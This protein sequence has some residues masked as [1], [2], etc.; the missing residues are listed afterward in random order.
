MIT[1]IGR[2]WIQSLTFF[3]NIR[4]GAR[5]RAMVWT[6]VYNKMS[7]LK[8]AGDKSIGEVYAVK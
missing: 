2:S 8:N 4:T 7:R 1:E 5:A 3:T 6:M